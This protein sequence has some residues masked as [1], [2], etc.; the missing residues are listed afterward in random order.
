M[1]EL[2][3]DIEEKDKRLLQHEENSNLIDH[4]KREAA[5]VDELNDQVTDL[6]SKYHF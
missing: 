1:I 6:E 4:W 3:K 2:T 5:K